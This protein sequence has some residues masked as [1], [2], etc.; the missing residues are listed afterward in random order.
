MAPRKGKPINLRGALLHN[1]LLRF[2]TLTNADLEAADISGADLAHARLD[3]ANLT[4]ANLSHACLDYASFEGANLTRLNSRGASLRFSKLAAA[5][6]EASDMSGANLTHARLN[7][8][9]LRAANLSNA[10]LDY[11]DFAGA[12]LTKVNLCGSSLK[13]AKN[14]TA[15]QLK[16]TT[17]SHSTIL[18]P[19][20]QGSVAWSV[21]R[22]QTPDSAALN[23]HDLRP[24]TRPAAGASVWQAHSYGRSVWMVVVLVIAAVL[25]IAGVWQHISLT[26]RTSAITVPASPIRT[27]DRVELVSLVQ[28]SAA[29]TLTDESAAELKSNRAFEGAPLLASVS[30]T[31]ESRRAAIP[32]SS[33]AAVIPDSAITHAIDVPAEALAGQAFE[34][35]TVALL[36]ETLRRRTC[37]PSSA[38]RRSVLTALPPGA[39]VSLTSVRE[40]T[41]PP[42]AT[43]PKAADRADVEPLTL[44]VSLSDQT[45]DVYRGTTLIASSKVSSGMPGHDTKT[46]IFSILEKQRFHRSNIYSGAPMPWMQRLTRSGTALHAGVVPGYPASH[47]CIRLP[48]SF[49]P[50]LFQMTNVGQT[51]VVANDRVTPKPIEDAKLFQPVRRPVALAMAHVE[52]IPQ[53]RSRDVSEV[54]AGDAVVPIALTAQRD[55]TIEVLSPSELVAAGSSERAARGDSGGGVMGDAPLRILVTRRTQR[56]TLIGVQHLLSAMG[57]L[58]PQ[59]FDGTFGKATVAAIEAFQKANGLTENGAFTDDFVQKIYQVAGQNEPPEGH[60]F[61]RQGFSR[62]FDAPIAFRNPSEPLGTHIFTA[63][64]FTLADTKTRWM[65][66]SVEGGDAVSA[67]DRI[68]IPDDIRQ[69]IS[70]R[71]TPGSSL[72]IADTSVDSAILPEGDD[73]LVWAKEPPAEAEQA[74]AKPAPAK[75]KQATA[76]PRTDGNRPRSARGSE[77]RSARRFDYGYPMGLD[78]PGLFSHWFSRR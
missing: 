25:L 29:R 76:K 62:A 10:C 7:R 52:R 41:P 42:W 55:A 68:E 28:P 21:A 12:D 18:P 20:L 31:F 60:L 57:Y 26:E 14:L 2:A 15:S 24:H 77:L 47:G 3:K 49:A 35:S 34:S 72:I 33:N 9:N 39:N 30:P 59:N 8:A 13:N 40:R 22:T 65:A 56:D 50:K 37:L 67:L 63:V 71:L 27:V 54:V 17:G 38:I 78:Q 48:F 1:S 70:E 5:D 44:S 19:H 69:K 53:R 61:V 6:L 58:A 66:L 36:H 45:I 46:G 11:A 43:A 4:T 64:K 75:T 23:G 51:V 74:K 16:G 32:S 73:F